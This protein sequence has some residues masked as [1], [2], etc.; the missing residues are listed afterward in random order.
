MELDAREKLWL[1]HIKTWQSSGMTQDAYCQ[2]NNLH[3][4]TFSNWKRR[5]REH[6]P[7]LPRRTN[8]IVVSRNPTT[9]LVPIKFTR[10]A[11]E[12][13]RL[14]QA[15]IKSPSE[16]VATARASTASCISLLV[17]DKYKVLVEASFDSSTLKR[18][19]SV[20]AEV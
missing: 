1:E 6:L 14:T 9:P 10:D 15:D 2:T 13:V 8:S 17:S 19:L 11:D 16:P 12:A 18:L 3:P 7:G 4:K 5:L 20:L